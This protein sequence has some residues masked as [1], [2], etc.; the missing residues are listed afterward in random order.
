MANHRSTVITGAE[1]V[2]GG[3]DELFLFYILLIK[4]FCIQFNI[5]L[6][7]IDLNDK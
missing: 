4:R 1:R 6:K 2:E 7:I 3:A 5:F